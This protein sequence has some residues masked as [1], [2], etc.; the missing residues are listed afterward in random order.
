MYVFLSPK[1]CLI[2]WIDLVF[3]MK[4]IDCIMKQAAQRKKKTFH[5][6]CQIFHGDLWRLVPFCHQIW[7]EKESTSFLR[8]GT[9]FFSEP[10]YLQDVLGELSQFGQSFPINAGQCEGGSWRQLISQ[11]VWKPKTEGRNALLG[12][13]QAEKEE[14]NQLYWAHIMYPVNTKII[15]A[16]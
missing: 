10:F 12:R 13:G 16:K 2:N 7:N 1:P 8:S 9:L 4:H 15:W 5:I 14:R 3:L 11:V 6:S